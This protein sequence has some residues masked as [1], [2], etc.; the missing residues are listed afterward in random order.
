MLIVVNKA[1]H[2]IGMVDPASAQQIAV[3]PANGDKP[4]EAAVSPDGRMAYVPIYGNS[5]VGKP[6]TNGRNMAVI[7]L[8]SRKIVGNV[9]FGHEVRPHCAVF[10]AGHNRLYVTTELDHTVTIIDPRTLKILGSVPT[11]QAESHMFAISSD[12][13][14]GYT[15]N[16]GPGTVS[17][18]DLV[19][20]KVI[21]IIP[22][23]AETQRISVSPD[24][25]LVFTSDQRKPQLAV[26]DAAADKI[27][28]WVPLPAVGYG[29]ASTHDGRWLLVAMP[30]ANQVAIIDL[31]SLKVARTIPVCGSPQ[32]ILVPPGSSTTA[33]VS[34]ESTHNVGVLNLSSWSM[35]TT[36]DVGKGPDGLAWAAA[37]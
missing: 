36:I 25:S 22:V 30:D 18:L 26:I 12:G 28:S 7:D 20:R 29:T 6:G 19:K 23:S 16:V 24:N 37:H 15:A 10:D 8:G 1:D 31:H 5:G 32:E 4:H 35:Q 34:C 2:T 27:K 3:I 14:R 17:V 13:L 9:D 21:T 11:G 33:Y